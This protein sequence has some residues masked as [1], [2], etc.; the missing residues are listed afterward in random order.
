[1]RAHA[2]K[3][4]VDF[5]LVNP[6]LHKQSHLNKPTL[7]K[8]EQKQSKVQADELM[9]EHVQEPLKDPHME[10]MIEAFFG[11]LDGE[12]T[13]NKERENDPSIQRLQQ[14][15]HTPVCEGSRASILR[16]CL[17]LLNPAE[18]PQVR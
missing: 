5:S 7:D 3:R 17:T 12:N 4:P 13:D 11:L 16:T 14:L 6:S 15:A 1:M 10:E 9:E 18:I 8:I 2:S